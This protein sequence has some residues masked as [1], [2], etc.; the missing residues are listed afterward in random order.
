[1]ESF[2]NVQCAIHAEIA[3]IYKYKFA[4]VAIDRDLF[5]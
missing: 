2:R 3:I 1:M 5:C 4:Y